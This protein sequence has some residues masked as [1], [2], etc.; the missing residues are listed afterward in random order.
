MTTLFDL[1]H[2][3]CKKVLSFRSLVS[4]LAYLPIKLVSVLDCMHV[5]F[6]QGEK[7]CLP[8]SLTVAG[9]MKEKFER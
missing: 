4:M 9:V 5:D 8:D 7:V 2:H 3:R 6:V 1:Q